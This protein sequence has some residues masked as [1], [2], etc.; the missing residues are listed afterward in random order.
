MNSIN[1]CRTIV[2]TRVSSASEVQV[3]FIGHD[4][5]AVFVETIKR[6]ARQGNFYSFLASTAKRLSFNQK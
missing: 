4:Y 3:D 1:S 5:Q 6:L 2:V